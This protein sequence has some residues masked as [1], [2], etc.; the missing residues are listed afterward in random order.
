MTLRDVARINESLDAYSMAVSLDDSTKIQ[1]V[2]THKKLSIS[3]LSLAGSIGQVL[4]ILLS[5]LHIHFRFAKFGVLW[6]DH[7]H[8]VVWPSTYRSL[9]GGIVHSISPP[10][11]VPAVKSA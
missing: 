2:S 7:Q 10:A 8:I 5:L 6:I 4:I 11:S 1:S 9:A 3:T